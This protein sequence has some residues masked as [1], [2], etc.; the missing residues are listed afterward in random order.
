[1]NMQWIRR[2]LAWRRA[3]PSDRLEAVLEE[4]RIEAAY[5]RFDARHKGYGPWLLAPMSERDAF[6]AEMRNTLA[7]E[8]TR[9]EAALRALANAAD[10]VGVEFFDTE[11]LH[12]L[13]QAMQDATQHARDVL[14]ASGA[15]SDGAH[16]AGYAAWFALTAE[17]L[18]CCVTCC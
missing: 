8:K 16:A 11:D 7:T 10:D 4:D 2:L 5:W 3:T 13:V 12:P 17:R 18:R 1:M 9:A 14:G 15:L 6:K